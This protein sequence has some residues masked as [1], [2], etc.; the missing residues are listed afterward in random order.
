MG[1]NRSLFIAPICT[2]NNPDECMCCRGV[3]CSVVWGRDPWDT[4]LISEGQIVLIMDQHVLLMCMSDSRS[5]K[6]VVTRDALIMCLIND[7]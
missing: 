6:D 3:I 7:Q 2:T 1:I 4:D 5:Q